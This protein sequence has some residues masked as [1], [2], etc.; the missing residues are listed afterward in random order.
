MSR[1]ALTLISPVAGAKLNEVPM[2]TGPPSLALSTTS[3][4]A[5]MSM[6]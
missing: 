3:R 1:P 2:R 4:V 5:L 6:A